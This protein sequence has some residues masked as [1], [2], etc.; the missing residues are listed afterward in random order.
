MSTAEDA[1]PIGDAE[2][3]RLFADL[4]HEPALVVAVSGG[5]DS[6][7]LL[8]LL[9][10][11]RMRCEPSPQLHAVT[12]DHGL[13]PQARSLR[14]DAGLDLYFVVRLH[15]LVHDYRHGGSPVRGR[16]TCVPVR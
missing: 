3:D 4:I 2:A 16:C 10:R 8:Y 13:R 7:A 15:N 1:R 6:T 12:I 14:I 5:P 9:A 11:W